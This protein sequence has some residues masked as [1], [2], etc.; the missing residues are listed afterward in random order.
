M[1]R[2]N[3]K[4]YKNWVSYAIR[5]KESRPNDVIDFKSVIA[6]PLVDFVVKYNKNNQEANLMVFNI[7]N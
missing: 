7:K 5:M 6:P 4:H 1:Y 3:I 2:L